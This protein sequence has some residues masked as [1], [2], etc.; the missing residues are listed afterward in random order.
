M[1]KLT[2]FSIIAAISICA[3]LAH[4]VD[5]K[6]LRSIGSDLAKAASLSDADI[7]AGSR[8]MMAQMDDQNGIAPT[9]SDYAQRLAGLT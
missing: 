4:A 7:I 1:K 8:N 6:S 9:G 2:K 3:G 5:L